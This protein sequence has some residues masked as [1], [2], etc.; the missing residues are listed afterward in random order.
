MREEREY[1]IET[2]SET[3][4]YYRVK[5]RSKRE[6]QQKYQDGVEEYVGCN[7]NANQR[8]LN[9]LTEKPYVSSR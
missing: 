4:L 6:A 3:Y 2:V 8:V 1:W 5:A 7:D 9:V